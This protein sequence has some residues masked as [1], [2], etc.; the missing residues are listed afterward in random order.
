MIFWCHQDPTQPVIDD[1]GVLDAAPEQREKKEKKKTVVETGD[2]A[3]A[4]SAAAAT[5]MNNL[6]ENQ[7]T[8]R[9]NSA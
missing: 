1:T 2:T 4:P 7:P 6:A 8:V 5:I 9:G 3:G